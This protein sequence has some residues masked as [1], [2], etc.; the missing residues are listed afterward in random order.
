MN[1]KMSDAAP[2]YA[3]IIVVAGVA[4]GSL[5]IVW[6]YQTVKRAF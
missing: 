3:L 1:W 6:I 4:A 2:L 5:L